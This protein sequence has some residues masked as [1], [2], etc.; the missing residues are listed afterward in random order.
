[1]H[2]A[3]TM[4]DDKMQP[5]VN[6]WLEISEAADTFACATRWSSPIVRR[7]WGHRVNRYPVSEHENRARGGVRIGALE[8][9]CEQYCSVKDR[10]KDQYI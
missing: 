9:L 2:S 6:D 7:L 3:G 1:M 8:E 4:T 10:A 5:N